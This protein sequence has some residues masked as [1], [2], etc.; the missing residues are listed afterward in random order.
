MPAKILS[1][2]INLTIEVGEIIMSHRKHSKNFSIKSDNTPVTKADK[3]SNELIIN[4]LKKLTPN[5]PILSEESSSIAFSVR[6]SWDEYWLIDPLDGTRDFIDGSPDFCISIALIRN[7]YPVF[8]L[9]YSPFHKIHYYRLPDQASIKIIGKT[10]HKIFTKK[11]KRWQKIVIGR[12]SN[13]NKPLKNHL[14][15]KTNF[16]IFKLGSALKFCLIAEGIYDYY[17]KFGRCSEWDTAAGVYILEGAG[18]T[19]LDLNNNPLT[20]NF[21]EDNLSPAFSALGYQENL[22][23]KSTE[24]TSFVTEPIEI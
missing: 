11:P 23:D 14:N 6:K 9:I 3:A 16:E 21:T 15:S 2:L 24:V 17:P 22:K 4:T 19:V 18:G 8:G 1:D 10:C 20:Y 12:Y 13:K 5:I 7:H